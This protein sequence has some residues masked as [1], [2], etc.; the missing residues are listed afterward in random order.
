MEDKKSVKI[1]LSTLLLIISIIIIAILSVVVYILVKENKTIKEDNAVEMI[2]E[3]YEDSEIDSI[4]NLEVLNNNIPNNKTEDENYDSKGIALPQL[5]GK[6]YNIESIVKEY[7]NIENVKNYKDFEF[8]LDNDSETDKITL[9][10]IVNED[11]NIYS[12]DRDYYALEYNGKSIYDHWYGMGIVGIID[13]DNTD[14]ILEIWV[15]DDGPSD[16]PC[17]IFFRKVGNEI[18]EIGSVEVDLSFYVD[19]KGRILAADRGMPWV[20]PS[21][22]DCYYTIENNEF[23]KND[24]DFS[25]DKLFEYTSEE[26]FFTENLENLENFKKDDTEVDDLVKKAEKYNINKLDKNT[27]FKIIEFTEREQYTSQNLKIELSDG[28]EGYLIHPYG[29]IYLYD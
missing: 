22:Y 21:V 14:N 24:L 17:Y 5:E 25:Y 19:G 15:Y 16:D 9:R 12:S 7:R 2:Q 26:C 3:N 28:T 27:K 6:F 8:D 23:I 4:E 1:G 13:L 10:H 11:E 18:I 29:V 20:E